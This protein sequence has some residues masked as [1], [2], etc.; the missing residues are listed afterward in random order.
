MTEASQT[1]G[2]ERHWAWSLKGVLIIYGIY[3]FLHGLIRF[4]GSQVIGQ[5]DVVGNIF[6]QVLVPGYIVR[7]GPL[8]DWLLWG[9]QQ[10]TGPYLISFLILKY[11]LLGGTVLFVYL[12]ARRILG[13]S[14]WA[15]LTAFSLSLLYQIGWNVHEGVTHTAALTSAIAASFWA[16]VRVVDYGRWGDYVLFGLCL[17]AGFLSKHTFGIFFVLLIG[18]SLMQAPLRRALLHPLIVVCLVTIL[19]MM[20]PYLFW[21]LERLGDLA[22]T[23]DGATGRAHLSYFERLLKGLPLLLL[24]PIGFFFPLILIL[25]FVFPGFWSA[26]RA[27]FFQGTSETS[28]PDFERLV[29]H[30]MIGALVLLCV[31]LFVFGVWRFYE[32]YLHPFFFIGLIALFAIARR[33]SYQD[34]HIKRYVGVLV[35]FGVVVA[36][37]R[38]AN[39]WVAEPFCKP[40]RQLVPYHG[41]R[42]ALLARGFRGG[43]IITGYRHL[44]G[45]MRRLFPQ[46]R[47]INVLDPKFIPPKFVNVPGFNDVAVVW[48]PRVNGEELPQVIRG[49]L[50]QLKI[51][52]A[53]RV[54][55]IKVPW[56][57]VWRSTGYR[58]SIWKL[59]VVKGGARQ[60]YADDSGFKKL[61]EGFVK[62]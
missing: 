56:T 52:D 53:P 15:A 18:A 30:M 6:T 2:L 51:K 8:Y 21:L 35:V 4:T 33:S 40:C 1:P 3:S 54:E 32:R 47:I 39:F 60:K 14:L 9:V 43:T 16:F 29:Y 49:V 12:S 25:P 38:V 41:I 19:I 24:G 59:A 48:S 20:S 31:G 62:K 46:A 5:D 22:T 44:G 34:L 55:T 23:V 36:G 11:A 57:H 7:Q 61:R 50:A 58:H 27:F 26:C 28:R 10:F 42:Q 13:S 45:N 37:I 17:G